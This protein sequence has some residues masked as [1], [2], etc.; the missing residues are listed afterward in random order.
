[1][2]KIVVGLLL[3]L[4]IAVYAK[5]AKPE[6]FALTAHVVSSELRREVTGSHPVQNTSTG[7]VYAN[8]AIQKK[9]Q[10]IVVNLDGKQYTLR[11]KKP[12]EV[13]VD[14]KVRF[15]SNKRDKVEVL[16]PENK[17]VKYEVVGVAEIP[18]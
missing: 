3:A 14:Y 15:T 7:Q 11:G 2:K 16:L 1:M 17:T 10:Y 9:V 12:L 4:A 5:G 8:V 6:D 18:K 13:G